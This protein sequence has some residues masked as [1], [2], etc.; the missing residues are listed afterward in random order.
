MT[1]KGV[2]VL[3]SP[4]RNLLRIFWLEAKF[5]FFKFLRL[6]IYS[7]SIL[8]FPTMFYI[9]FGLS[10]GRGEFGPIASALY[11]AITYGAFGIIG[12][13]LFGFGVGV[14]VER[15][16]GWMLL[17]RASP[18]PPLAYFLAKVFMAAMFGLIIVLILL[19]L[20]ALFGG[21]RLS[22]GEL[23]SVIG[24]LVVGTLPFSAMGL[25]LGYLVGPNSA[26]AVVNLI[27]LPMSFAAGL[28][29]PIQV[30]P[31]F[32]QKLAPYLPTYHYAQLSLGIVGA[33]RGGGA[34]WHL[35]VLGGFTLAFL[36]AAVFL[37]FRDEGQTYG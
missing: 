35:L 10:F 18:M 33:D 21:L 28:W 30:L 25:A 4:R 37:Y 12:A 3:E 15:G 7:L 1:V 29:I 36:I 32:F 2:G 8:L 24:V 20:G 22:V 16:Q 31:A 11:Y 27:Y 17:K 23:L 13:A 5:E 14:A 6:P 19:A 26:P 9:L 34:G